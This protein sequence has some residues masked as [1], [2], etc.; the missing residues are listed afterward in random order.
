MGVTIVAPMLQTP[1]DGDTVSN[2]TPTFVWNAPSEAKGY[3]FQLDDDSN[4]ANPELD[5]MT[6]N[7]A[8]VVQPTSIVG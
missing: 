3:Q 2:N 7:V 8:L 4:F 6:S 5:V 1:T